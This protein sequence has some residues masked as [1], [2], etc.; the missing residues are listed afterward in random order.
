VSIAHARLFVHS[1]YDRKDT[2]H[3]APFE[4]WNSF[5]AMSSGCSHPA[6]KP[7]TVADRKPQGGCFLVHVEERCAC[8]NFQRVQEGKHASLGR[9]GG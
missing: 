2:D 6:E 9:L 8:L 3:R 1:L 5:A 7:S 4:K